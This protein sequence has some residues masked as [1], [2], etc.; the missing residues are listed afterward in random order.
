MM[1][2]T[3]RVFMLHRLSMRIVI[4]MGLAFLFAGAS[5]LGVVRA[6]AFCL[7]ADGD[8]QPHVVL[9]GGDDVSAASDCAVAETSVCGVDCP[10][11]TDFV[12]QSVE[13]LAARAANPF[14]GSLPLSKFSSGAQSIPETCFR[15]ELAGCA[16]RPSLKLTRATPIAERVH[17]TIV[18]RI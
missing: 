17:R 13:L 1:I 6:V 12:I 4:T 14:P 8:V 18:L 2:L 5:V 16:S 7:Y 10:P 3:Q 11:C 9:L 15:P